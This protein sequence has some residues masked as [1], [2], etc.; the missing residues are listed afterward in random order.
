MDMVNHSVT[1]V[2]KYWAEVEKYVYIC[3]AQLASENGS[4]ILS[5]QNIKQPFRLTVR[6]CLTL[7]PRN[8]DSLEPWS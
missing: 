8:T 1:N 7:K 4:H 3:H 5:I 6:S 2:C